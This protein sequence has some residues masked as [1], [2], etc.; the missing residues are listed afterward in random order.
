MATSLE[1]IDV[2][3]KHKLQGC[4]LVYTS[5]NSQTLHK[6][7]GT[8]FSLLGMWPCLHINK[9]QGCGLVYTSINSMDVAMFTHQ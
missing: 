3:T 6:V 1:F 4:G 7:I 2:E 9:L 8:L 5:I